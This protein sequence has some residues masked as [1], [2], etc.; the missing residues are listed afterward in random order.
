MKRPTPAETQAWR[1]RSGGLSRRS[2]PPKRKPVSPA[3]TAQ[4]EKVRDALCLITGQRGCDPAHV[5]P[6]SQGGCDSPDCVIPLSRQAHRAFDS[7]DLDVLP[8]MIAAGMV[9]E[10]AHALEHAG[11]PLTLLERLTGERWV[12]RNDLTDD[13]EETR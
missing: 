10:M 1:A 12:P 11:S 5:I 3:S 9:A 7:G 6:R 8:A 2:S 13:Q 4:R